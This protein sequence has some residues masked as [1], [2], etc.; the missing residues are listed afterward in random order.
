[1]TH[2]GR[3]HTCLST[4]Q[5][6]ARVRVDNF[7]GARL[8]RTKALKPSP[9]ASQ[10]QHWQGA[11]IRSQPGIKPWHANVRPWFPN[12]STAKPNAPPTA[13]T[14]QAEPLSRLP[15]KRG[16]WNS[17]QRLISLSLIFPGFKHIIPSV[18]TSFLWSNNIPLYSQSL[19]PIYSFMYW[20]TFVWFPY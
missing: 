6:Q 17:V 10:G 19:Q 18:R 16:S 9:A 2:K 4:A 5:M 12:N 11:E 8:G 3:K 1:M 20:W 14:Q 15:L 7:P 13:C